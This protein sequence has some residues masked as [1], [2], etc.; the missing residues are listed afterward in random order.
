MAGVLPNITT[1]KVIKKGE[2]KKKLDFVFLEKT[3]NPMCTE[4]NWENVARRKIMTKV[5]DPLLHP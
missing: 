2:K 3:G 5:A 1:K 4:G